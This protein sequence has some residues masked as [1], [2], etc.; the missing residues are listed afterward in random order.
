MIQKYGYGYEGYYP[1]FIYRG[2]DLNDID[3]ECAVIGIKWKDNGFYAYTGVGNYEDDTDFPHML[4][5]IVEDGF[6]G[7]HLGT[8]QYFLKS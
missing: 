5:A 6:Y 2:F 8:P 4:K 3:D 7:K 1:K